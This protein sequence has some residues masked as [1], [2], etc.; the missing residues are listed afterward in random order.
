[1][2][3]SYTMK[4]N[5]QSPTSLEPTNSPISRKEIEAFANQICGLFLELNEYGFGLKEF[6]VDF[7]FEFNSGRGRCISDEFL[8][9]NGDQVR[10]EF[11]FTPEIKERTELPPHDKTVYIKLDDPNSLKLTQTVLYDVRFNARVIDVEGR[12]ISDKEVVLYYQDIMK[13]GKFDDD[14]VFSN[15]FYHLITNGKGR[16]YPYYH[17]ISEVAV[18]GRSALYMS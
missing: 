10:F 8:G 13:K 4:P 15:L 11:S 2:D 14:M 17:F 18:H 7:T 5:S 9:F 16:R 6:P 12:S 3:T 1:M